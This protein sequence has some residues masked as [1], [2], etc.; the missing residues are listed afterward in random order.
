MT[1]REIVVNGRG[2]TAHNNHEQ[3]CLILTLISQYWYL[4]ER[5]LLAYRL[6][7]IIMRVWER[8]A[9]FFW[10]NEWFLVKRILAVRHHTLV[11]FLSYKR[12]CLTTSFYGTLHVRTG[13]HFESGPFLLKKY[14]RSS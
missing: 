4:L 5:P 9:K 13:G 6:V 12:I 3:R 2:L 7:L 14:Y 1:V 10:R 8:R 11:P